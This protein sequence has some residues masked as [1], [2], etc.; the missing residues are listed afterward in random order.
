MAGVGSDFALMSGEVPTETFTKLT[1]LKEKKLKKLATLAF[2]TLGLTLGS[3]AFG[4]G[5][6]STATASA[7][8][9]IITP[10]SISKIADLNF[11]SVI[12][13]PCTG[14]VVYDTTGVRTASGCATLGS[15]SFATLASFAVAGQVNATYAIT[16][17]SSPITIF[18]S[19]SDALG[20]RTTSKRRSLASPQISTL[21]LAGLKPVAPTWKRPPETVRAPVE[22]SMAAVPAP[23]VTAKEPKF[24]SAVLAIAIDETPPHVW[25]AQIPGNPKAPEATTI[26]SAL[27]QKPIISLPCRTPF[28]KATC[29]SSSA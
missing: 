12:T 5:N 26:R 7:S 2:A 10:I 18:D 21:K 17:P 15:G 19:V 16:L 20:G 28:R 13:G 1:K 14:T 23:P 3:Y 29:S 25:E 6:T 11:D 22:G 4:Q 9:T 27:F 24:K 8:A